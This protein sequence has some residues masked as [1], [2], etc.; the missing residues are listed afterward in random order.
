MLSIID[1]SIIY[2]VIVVV[3]GGI[4]IFVFGALYIIRKGRDLRR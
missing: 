4:V 3:D 2:I 1:D